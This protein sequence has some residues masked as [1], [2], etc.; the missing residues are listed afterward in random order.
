MWRA[1]TLA[2]KNTVGRYT[3]P[4]ECRSKTKKFLLVPPVGIEPT[5]TA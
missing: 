2:Q 3:P 5:S 4:T 1:S